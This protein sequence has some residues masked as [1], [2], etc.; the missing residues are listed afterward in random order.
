MLSRWRASI[1]ASLVDETFISANNIDSE[2]NGAGDPDAR[3]GKTDS[4]EVVDFS[5]RYDVKNNAYIF[6]GVHNVSGEE[7]IVSRQPYGSRP[8]APRTWL[9][10]FEVV[11]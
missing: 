9:M 8:G 4:Y 2:I 10:G 1:G 3:F 7:Y 6:A 5:V 11:M